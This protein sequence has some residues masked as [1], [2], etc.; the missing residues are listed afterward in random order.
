MLDS[1]S[2]LVGLLGGAAAAGFAGWFVS[3]WLGD[4]HPVAVAGYDPTQAQQFAS[5]AQQALNQN[6]A[7]FLQLVRTELDG[8]FGRER[9]A[10]TGAV[11]P[12]KDSLVQVQGLVRSIEEERNKAY[13]S[14]ESNLKNLLSA[15][16]SLQQETTTLSSTLRNPQ[17]RGRWGEVALRRLVELSGLTEHCDF[18]TQVTLDGIDERLRPD[19]VIRLPSGRVVP[20]DSKV[21]ISA[22]LDAVE[23]KAPDERHASLKKHAAQVRARLNDLSGKEYAEN[24][25]G[26][27]EAPEFAI[28]FIPGD[29]FLAAALAVDPDLFEDGAAKKVM[30][31]SP[32]ILLPMLR[33]V[34]VGW[35]QE[36]FLKNIEQLRE[37]ARVL[38]DRLAGLTEHLGVLG[39]KLDGAVKEYNAFVGSYDSRVIPQARKF[40]SMGVQGSKSLPDVA[41][42][43]ASPREPKGSE[44]PRVADSSKP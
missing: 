33:V 29:D 9:E 36:R 19:L 23:A 10:L 27:G 41:Q 1:T 21:S 11:A 24:L 15:T 28:M 16:A 17:A 39:K 42:I 22:Y 44:L 5:V 25:R 32:T 8:Q 40:E 4:H 7:H 43:E 35:R 38:Y 20:V 13:G 18:D 12:L 2:I 14:L 34:E 3:R 26:L 37:E 31:A 30:L 6:S